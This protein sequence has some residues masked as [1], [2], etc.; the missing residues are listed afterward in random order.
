MTIQPESFTLDELKDKLKTLSLRMALLQREL[1][2]S[3]REFLLLEA[4][5][6]RR[7]RLV[8]VVTHV[9]GAARP[10][11]KRLAAPDSLEEFLSRVA[12]LEPRSRERLLGA[13]PLNLQEEVR[14]RL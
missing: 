8:L 9:G 1:T 7:E 14:K 4:E 11:C 10:S 12:E 5:K 3:G 2:E 13:L 6:L